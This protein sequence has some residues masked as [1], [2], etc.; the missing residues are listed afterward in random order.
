MSAVEILVALAILVGLA[1]IVV[2]ILPGVVLIVVA[3]GVWAL[4]EGSA[5]GWG[6]FAIAVTVIALGQYLKYAIPGHQLKASGVPNR[7]LVAGGL[8]GIVG[9]FV[10]PVVGLF[11]G[12]VL[13][14][15][16]SEYQRIGGRAAWP[17]TRAALRAV[18]WSIL[19]EL[20]AALVAT[21]VWIAGVIAI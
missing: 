4:A 11:V 20:A 7:S 6:V 21:T 3:L 12:F 19:I 5:A 1:G 16:A 17:S 14:I 15:Y 13:G 2:P 9:F 8:L 18:G 10:V